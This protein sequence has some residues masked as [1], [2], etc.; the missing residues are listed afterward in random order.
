MPDTTI[1]E[2]KKQIQQWDWATL[3]KEALSNVEEREDGDGLFGM[4]FIGTVFNLIPSG[5]YY[6]P[7][8]ASNVEL[9]PKCGGEKQIKRRRANEVRHTELVNQQR[10]LR[11]EAIALYGAFSEGRW[12][13]EV[14]EQIESL[15]KEIQSTAPTRT[16]PMCG[17]VGSREAYL[18]SLFEEALNE[19][20]EDNGMWITSGEGDL[21]DMFAGIN[22][23]EDEESQQAVVSK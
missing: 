10:L 23:E 3:K 16:C 22:V 8:A 11:L 15:D 6:T 21:C 14:I 18:D 19:V 9:C 7:W 13:P 17:G 1:N 4:T 5:K 12:T 2:F 20:A